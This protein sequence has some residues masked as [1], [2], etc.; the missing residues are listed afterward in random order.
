MDQKI[1]ERIFGALII[2]ALGV[3]FLPMLFPG[4][5]VVDKP[6]ERT[7]SPPMNIKHDVVPPA[8]VAQ[9]QKEIKQERPVMPKPSPQLQEK[10]F[11]VQLA[12]FANKDNAKALAIKLQN[13]GYPA[14]V[15]QVP[16][17]E[18]ALTWVLVGPKVDKHEAVKLQEKLQAQFKL[19]GMVVSYQPTKV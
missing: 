14:Y 7:V 4:N 3:I 11:V 12:T 15:Q 1:K 8:E 5:K 2:I 18:D 19:K 17:K 6:F 13:Q 16:G 10:A 9:L